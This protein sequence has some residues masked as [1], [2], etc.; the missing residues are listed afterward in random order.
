MLCAW[1]TV[2]QQEN[3]AHFPE[4]ASRPRRDEVRNARMR[5]DSLYPG[6]ERAMTRKLSIVFLVWL[7]TIVAAV[8]AR[9]Q[10]ATPAGADLAA[11]SACPSWC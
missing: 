10:V 4:P 5:C 11:D 3:V 9:A 6:K 8:G 1:E 7:L 2:Y